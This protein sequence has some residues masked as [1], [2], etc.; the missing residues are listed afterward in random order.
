[1]I[2]FSLGDID[3][4]RGSSSYSEDIF[5]SVAICN[6]DAPDGASPRSPAADAGNNVEVG[7]VPQ[8]PTGRSVGRHPG[9]LGKE[10]RNKINSSLPSV[11]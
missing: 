3:I 11:Q 5:E 1:M 2:H 8:L 9:D 10:I 6:S 4:L 7:R